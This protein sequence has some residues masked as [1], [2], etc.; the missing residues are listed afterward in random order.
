MDIE[1]ESLLIL[2]RV[3]WVHGHQ[4]NMWVLKAGECNAALGADIQR[5]PVF[6]RL[7]PQSQKQ[8]RMRAAGSVLSPALSR[9]LVSLCLS[10]LRCEMGLIT[11]ILSTSRDFV[12][13]EG[14]SARRAL[15]WG[16][17]PGQTLFSAFGE[18]DL[19]LSSLQGGG[20]SLCPLHRQ[21]N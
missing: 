13:D 19:T 8:P 11:F 17:C 3:A 9:S 16:L 12:Q 7:F 20:I 21:E 2:P 5:L 4:E 14:M 6:I 15:R 18:G 10:V 1:C